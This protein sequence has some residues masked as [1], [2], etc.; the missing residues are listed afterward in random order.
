M[1]TFYIRNRHSV[2]VIHFDFAKAFDTVIHPKLIHKLQ[3]YGFCDNL[4]DVLHA[5]LRDRV[6]RVVLHNGVP[7]FCQIT[8]GVP[9]GSV[10]GPILFLIYINGIVD[11]FDGNCV[12]IKLYA[13][14][15]K[16][17]LE[18]TCNSDTK[19]LQNILYK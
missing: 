3:A 17:Y 9:Q 18:I 15:L 19:I 5:F 7:E 8:S 6:Q 14:D 13:D 4:L 2:D 12:Q 11:L 1:D 10:L 16:V